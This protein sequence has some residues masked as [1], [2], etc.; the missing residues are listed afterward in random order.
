VEDLTR[1][2]HAYRDGIE[3]NPRRLQQVEERL[4]LIYSLKRKYGDSIAEILAFGEAAEEELST[5]SHSEERVEELKVEEDKLLHEVGE[6]AAQLSSERRQASDRLAEA[7]EA[8]LADLNME[9]ARFAISIEQARAEDG[10]WMGDERYA[11]D[12][13]GV[14]RV[15][16]LIAPNVGEPLKPLARVASGGEAS[17]LMLALKTVLSAADEIP[18]LIFDE[19]D[20]GI[21]GRVGGVVGR[22]LWTLTLGE[23]ADDVGHQVFCVTHLPQLA[24]YGDLHFRVNKEVTEGRTLTSV[25][26]LTEEGRLAELAQMLGAVTEVTRRNAEEMVEGAR[27]VK[28]SSNLGSPSNPQ[29]GAQFDCAPTKALRVPGGP[30]ETPAT[31]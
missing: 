11:F 12:V 6:L 27:R 3:Y 20:S 9:K 18:I 31:C 2:L 24:S 28:K 8:E 7:V 15:E 17:R 16:F 10:A 29:V 5:I 1:V 13:T 19:I 30:D 4:N 21:G 22:K 26:R 23:G 14:D 25:Q